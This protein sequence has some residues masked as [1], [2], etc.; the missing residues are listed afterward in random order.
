MLSLVRVGAG[1]GFMPN[2][3]F[4]AAPRPGLRAVRI[5]KKGVLRSWRAVMNRKRS[6]HIDKFV[7][8][9]RSKTQRA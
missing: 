5:G 2:W 9:L 4:A 8:L 1:I 6:G 7:E 3:M